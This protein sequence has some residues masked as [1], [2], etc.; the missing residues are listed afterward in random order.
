MSSSVKEGT[1]SDVKRNEAVHDG[2][3]YLVLSVAE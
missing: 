3:Q 1:S 2:K